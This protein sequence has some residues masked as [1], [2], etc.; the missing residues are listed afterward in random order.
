MRS[1]GPR[2]AKDIM[3]DPIPYIEQIKQRIEAYNKKMS[4]KKEET[5]DD[6]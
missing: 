1:R 6:I 3:N 4:E 2:L 5:G